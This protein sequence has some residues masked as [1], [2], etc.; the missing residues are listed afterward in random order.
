MSYG[1]SDYILQG[2]P[3]HFKDFTDHPPQ[4]QDQARAANTFSLDYR[5]TFRFSLT[6][7]NGASRLTSGIKEGRLS[8][9]QPLL[10]FSKSTLYPA[11]PFIF[12]GWQ[13]FVGGGLTSQVD[14]LNTVDGNLFVWGAK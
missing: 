11:D 5:R 9:H 4:F 12:F 13:D 3:F 2:T 1:S 6:R 8:I 7:T 14:M 10:F